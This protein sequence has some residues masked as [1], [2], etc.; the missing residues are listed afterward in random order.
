MSEVELKRALYKALE[1][2]HAAHATYHRA[3][4]EVRM[5]ERA[6]GRRNA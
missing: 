2:S 1:V 5:A 6:L 4:H 3:K